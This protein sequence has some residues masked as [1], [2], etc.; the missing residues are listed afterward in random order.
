MKQS[1]AKLK[2]KNSEELLTMWIFCLRAKTIP[3]IVETIKKSKL[4][5]LHTIPLA[6]KFII[7]LT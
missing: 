7:Y 6:K 1:K 2:K 3:K 5:R 4:P